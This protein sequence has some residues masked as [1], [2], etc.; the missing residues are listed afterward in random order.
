MTSWRPPGS[1]LEAPDSIL[2]AP[3]LDLG[4]FWHDFFDILGQNA[5]KAKNAKNAC[6]NK[7]AITNPPRVGGRRCSPPG[8]FQWNWSQVGLKS[9][10]NLYLGLQIRICL[11]PTS[12][13]SR[14]W[15][16]N[17]NFYWFWLVFSWILMASGFKNSYEVALQ[18]E[19]LFH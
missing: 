4:R 19:K 17:L 5:K 11:P 9:P 7:T 2:E 16:P 13:Y 8:G 15:P 12:N 10:K 1:I 6:Q 14:F 18:V 3:K